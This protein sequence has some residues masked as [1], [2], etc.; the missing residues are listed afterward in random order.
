MG[1]LSPLR[2]SQTRSFLSSFS[3]YHLYARPLP[4]VSWCITRKNSY[5][6]LPVL[7]VILPNLP[8]SELIFNNQDSL[9]VLSPR[10]RP[11]SK[12]TLNQR[13]RSAGVLLMCSHGFL[14]PV[15]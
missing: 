12:A 13:D 9:S 5:L 15:S 2:K 8:G 14:H 10:F 7:H 11:G 1:L 6:L 4:S 3:C